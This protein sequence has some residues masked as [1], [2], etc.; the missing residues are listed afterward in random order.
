[1]DKT[2]PTVVPPV[3]PAAIAIKR[4]RRPLSREDI[5][6]AAEARATTYADIGLGEVLVVDGYGVMVA[7]RRGCLEV[8]DGVGERR[9]VR[10]IARSDANRRV[11]RVFVLGVGAVSTAAMAWCAEQHLPLIVAR[12][13]SAEPY[14]VGAPT[15]FD[16]G[17]LRRAQA[18]APFTP[19][20]MAVVRWLLDVRLA[21]Q[22]R[23]A[24]KLLDRS[25][26]AATI[27]SQRALLSDCETVEEAMTVEGGAADYFWQAFS[28]LEVSFASQDRRRV[29]DGWQN[30]H[31]R[32]SPLTTE[33]WSNRHAADVPNSLLNF[34]YWLCQTEATIACL[35]LGIDPAMGLA[36]ANRQGRP[37]AALD[38]MEAGRGVVE[39][40][41]VQLM[42]QRTFRKAAFV[43]SRSG[44]VR[45]AAPLSHELAQVLSPVLRETLGPVVERLAAMIAAVADGSLS[46]P[47]PLSRTRHGKRPRL[48][49]ARFKRTCRGC[50]RSLGMEEQHRAWCDLCLPRARLERDLATIGPARRRKRPPR[51]DYE[52]ESAEQRARTMTERVAEQQAWERAH[53]GTPRPS[54]ADFEPI[55]DAL[56]GISLSRLAGAIDVSQTAASKIR[57]GELVPHFRHWPALAE[58][59]APHTD[60]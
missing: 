20:G 42:R 22:S 28:S 31:G 21:D 32:R 12:P 44:E 24:A 59:C 57:R 43:E 27:E 4:D 16:H 1:M 56:A 7:V 18:L 47:T 50:G 3:E 13:G 30:F 58:L 10:T 38:V 48:N 39:E 55:R 6:D 54:P 15:L 2:D 46:V 37:A 5:G 35:A 25:D 9:R 8:R 34:G 49:A 29:P 26:V 45:L 51:R 40:S 53:R 11:R 19:T 36:H 17:G 14:M 52:S 60:I 33:Q 41:V 23:I